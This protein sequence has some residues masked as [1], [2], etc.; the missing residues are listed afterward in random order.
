MWLVCIFFVSSRRCSGM[1]LQW[2]SLQARQVPR[3]SQGGIKGSLAPPNTAKKLSWFIKTK[4]YIE[5]FPN[6]EML[7]LATSCLPWVSFSFQHTRF[8]T[9]LRKKLSWVRHQKVKPSIQF[10]LGSCQNY[11]KQTSLD[12]WVKLEQS[13][14]IAF[15]ASGDCWKIHGPEGAFYSKS[16]PTPGLTLQSENGYILRSCVS[17]QEGC[18]TKHLICFSGSGNRTAQTSAG[19]GDH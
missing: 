16:S 13:L 2:W 3:E 4:I 6:A 9:L 11:V 14:K 15:T 1:H 19:L 12:C 17:C 5:K 8:I 10:Q 18:S 7:T